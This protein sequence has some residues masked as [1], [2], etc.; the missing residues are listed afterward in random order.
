MSF[1]ITGTDTDVGKT[2]YA[3]LLIRALRAAGHDAVGM[4][5]IACGPN[6]D[7]ELLR[8]ASGK[9]VTL[10]DLNP[11][12]FAAPLAPLAAGRLEDR[13]TDIAQILASFERLRSRH[14]I[15]IV[16][17]A[18]G[19]LV[20][21]LKDFSMADLARAMGLPVILVVLNRLGAI[22]H[23]LLTLE[24]I[25]RAGLTCAGI[26]LNHVTDDPA[27]PAVQTNRTILTEL[28]TVPLLGDIVAGQTSLDP[29]DLPQGV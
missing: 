11:V 29:N 6:E 3:A 28:T 24:S 18:G 21:I 15:V 27:D 10:A 7:T 5:P 9:D 14:E 23:T 19:W 8:Q 26:V 20:P 4:K 1:F 22:N 25:D 2:Y 17:G 16:E 13:T 12:H